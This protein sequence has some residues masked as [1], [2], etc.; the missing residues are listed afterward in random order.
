MYA[1]GCIH[2]KFDIYSVVNHYYAVVFVS[3]WEG[4]PHIPTQKG[5]PCSREKQAYI[6]GSLKPTNPSN[7]NT[8]YTRRKKSNE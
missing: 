2:G 7:F 4:N 1:T 6:A 8:K 3:P 5:N